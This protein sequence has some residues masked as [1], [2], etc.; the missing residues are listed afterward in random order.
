LV[1]FVPGDSTAVTATYD[2]TVTVRCH[3]PDLVRVGVQEVLELEEWRRPRLSAGHSLRY[4]LHIE[5]MPESTRKR[6]ASDFSERI[7]D[8]IERDEY[9]ILGMTPHPK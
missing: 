2:I 9:V 5:S 8:Q 6:Y 3:M 1:L 7:R 4:T